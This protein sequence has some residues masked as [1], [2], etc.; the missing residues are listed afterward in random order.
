[1]AEAGVVI[2]TWN[3]A[4]TIEACVRSVPAGVPVVVVDNASQDDTVE[5][6]LTAR[7]DARIVRSPRN[8]GFGAA[9][10]LGAREL[11]DCD[12]LLLNPDAELLPD[13]LSYLASRLADDP[14]LGAVGPLLTDP[15][16]GLELSW[17]ADP[18]LR[19]EWR[20]RREHGAKPVIGS[21]CPMRVDWV[22]GAC[23]LIR[24]TAWEAV[25]GFDERFFLYF[26]DL[27]LCRRLRERHF[28]VLF[29][30]GASARHLR[31]ASSDSLGPAKEARYRESQLRYYRLHAR[32]LSRVGLRL[33]LV[34]KYAWALVRRPHHAAYYLP[35]LWRAI[36][37][38]GRSAATVQ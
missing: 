28:G 29:D 16:G 26:E 38:A 22:T 30:P 21:L 32:L 1:M 20:R 31:G 18:S 33:Y 13:T 7:P 5:R 2:V 14:Q 37:G 6:A 27:D 17:G 8:L 11:G 35:I 24:R 36:T 34:A 23:C 4:E 19:S 9:C 25:G 10:N 3:S 12:V 15:A